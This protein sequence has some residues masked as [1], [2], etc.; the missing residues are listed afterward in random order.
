MVLSLARTLSLCQYHDISNRFLCGLPLNAEALNASEVV[1][2]KHCVSMSGR[3][4]LVYANII[5]KKR[6]DS[7]LNG[8]ESEK[9]FERTRLF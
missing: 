1:A 3:R 5:A 9:F 8:S 4:R 2:L 6:H 7:R